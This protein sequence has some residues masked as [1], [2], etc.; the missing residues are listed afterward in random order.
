MGYK[1]LIRRLLRITR[2]T[3]VYYKWLFPDS[4]IR[5]F[6]GFKPH[7][8]PPVRILNNVIC[9]NE[10]KVG[11]YTFVAFNVTLGPSLKRIGRYCSIGP[12]AKIGLNNHPINY[13]STSAVFYSVNWKVCNDDLRTEF[14][15][16][17]DVTVIEHDV[18]IGENAIILSGVTLAIG[19]LVAAGAVVS[20]NT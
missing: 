20:K 17:R 4:T 18:W 15:Q 2:L 3:W 9:H 6:I 14:Y 16:N 7:V 5:S 10:L 12:G 19:T 1:I 11:H 13:F 8:E